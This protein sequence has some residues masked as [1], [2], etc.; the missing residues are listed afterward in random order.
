[1]YWHPALGV[2]CITRLTRQALCPCMCLTEF[3][4]YCVVTGI[5]L[6]IILLCLFYLESDSRCS[7]Q[8]SSKYKELISKA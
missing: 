5:F 6:S 7:Q 8:D 2:A 4:S 1:M 3:P